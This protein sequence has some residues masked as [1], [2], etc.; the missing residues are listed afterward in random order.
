MTELNS[1]DIEGHRHELS[2]AIK[3]GDRAREGRAYYN[4]ASAYREIGDFKQ[5]VEYYMQHLSIVKELGDRHGEARAYGNIG[6]AYHRLG[7]FKK[8]IDYQNL[9]L[10][11]AKELG[12]RGAEGAAY[13]NLGC[14]YEKIGDF[15]EAVKHHRLRLSIAKELGEKAK[16][17]RAYENLGDA[18]SSLGDFKQAIKYYNL[19]LGIAKDMEDR[20]CEGRAY[21]NIGKCYQH[22]GDFKKAAENH[23]LV[24]SIAKEI[25]DKTFEVAAYGNLGIVYKSLG[26]FKQA[27]EYHSLCL[28]T[29]KELG[30]RA[31]EGCAYGN[32]GVLHQNLGNFKQAKEFHCLRLSIAKELEDKASEGSSYGNLGNAY[33]SLGDFRQSIECHMQHLGIAKDVGDRFGEACAYGNLGIAY[34][35]LG[36]FEEAIEYHKQHLKIVKKMGDRFSEGSAY[37]NLGNAYAKL[38]NFEKAMEYQNLD[39]RIAKEV[40]DRAGEGAAYS[41]LGHTWRNLGDLSQAMEHYNLGISIAKEVGSRAGE[42]TAYSGLGDAYHDL[43]NFKQAMECH[44]QHLNIAKELGD[45]YGEG[46]ASWSLGLDCEFL[47]LLHEALNYYK[48]SVL[49]YSDM[50]SLLQSEDAWKITFRDSLQCTFTALWRTLVKLQKTDEALCVAEQGRAQAL[51]DLMKLR[52]GFG[53]PS[54]TDELKETISVIVSN[55][56][57]QTVF[58]ALESNTINFWVLCKENGVQF[59]QKDTDVEDDDD[60]A[61]FLQGLIKDAF[62]ENGIGVGVL[63]EDRSLDELRSGDPFHKKSVLEPIKSPLHNEKSPL[64]I[65]HDAV[66]GPIANLLQG[67][68][69]IIVPDGP[70]CMAPYAA[71]VDQEW[72]CLSENKRIRIIP[73]LSSLKLI[74]DCPEGYHSRDGALLVGN[75]CVEE[76]TNKRGRPLLS[77]LPYAREEVE[78]I[79]KILNTTPLTGKEAT[80]EEVLNQITSAALVHIAAHGKMETGEIALAPNPART[81]KIPEEK[82]FIL[83]MAD[84]QAVQLRARLVVLSCCHSGRG[85][86]AAEGVVGIARAFLSAGARSV[87]VTLWAIDDEATMEFMRIF[88]RHLADRSSA[89]VALHRAMKV[90]RESER[91]GDMKYWAP[92]VLIGDDTMLEFGFGEN[93]KSDCKYLCATKA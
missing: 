77:P 28:S 11:I 87:L 8:A 13:G 35:S 62:N 78:M 5:A 7:D 84:V 53:H 61:S 17:G 12:N 9:H 23:N 42:G 60:A 93:K 34:F 1:E 31:S 54:L 46:R 24:H 45:R 25:C 48:S 2:I 51:I 64:R 20:S 65:L 91:F 63:C 85:K 71:F 36:D 86:I 59:V 58:I 76:V 90:L 10:N 80:K 81:A 38:G 70:L 37:C 15:K 3:L 49:L 18:C 4:L 89:S 52:Y 6:N 57:T 30:D 39:L 33:G 74:A 19:R 14:A 40:G 41:N 72:E 50:R 21:S 47:G 55:I 43:D 22:L 92:F 29:A 32:L 68:E 16:E 56:S 66:I 44:T 75:P 88:Y 83:T 79:G 69:L 27:I 73:S 82:D 26:K 67:E